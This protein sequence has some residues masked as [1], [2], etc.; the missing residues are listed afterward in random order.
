MTQAK[1]LDVRQKELQALLTTATGRAELERLAAR[2][3]D[4]SGRL[5]PART[6]LITYIVVHERERGLVAG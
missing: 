6:S 5:R 3:A 4:A 1:T 2:Y